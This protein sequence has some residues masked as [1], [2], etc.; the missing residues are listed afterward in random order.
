MKYNLNL[1]NWNTVFAVPRILVEKYINTA[2]FVQ[3]KVLLWILSNKEIDSVE[4]C[5]DLNISLKEFKESFDYWDKNG[6]FSIHKED[7]FK[8]TENNQTSS[9]LQHKFQRPDYSYIVSR[10]KESDEISMMV[11]EV[12]NILR[13][14]LS[15]SDISIFLMLH[16]NEG[17]PVDVILM[18]VRHCFDNGKSNMRYIYKVGTDWGQSGVDSIE[19]AEHKIE[20]SN[21]TDALWKRFQSIIGIEYRLP[22]PTEET[23]V[24]RW[25]QDWKFK[26]ELIKYAYEICVDSKGKYIIKYM[27]SIL[28]KWYNQGI[29]TIEDAMESRRHFKTKYNNDSKYTSYNIEEYEN[30]SI[31]D[32]N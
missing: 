30:Y 12:Q 32:D 15:T 13:R 27:D 7:L 9:T 19:K 29:F 5:E 25:Y 21:R 8:R 14:P 22:T 1:G 23:I 26:D 28:R 31:F 2:S 6:F 24:R 20:Y 10:V 4:A 18:L 16:D 11:K 3:I 17:L